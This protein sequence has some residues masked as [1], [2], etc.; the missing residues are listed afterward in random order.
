MVEI[1]LFMCFFLHL[2]IYVHANFKHSIKTLLCDI[3]FYFYQPKL[4]KL[5]FDNISE[6]LNDEPESIAG[7]K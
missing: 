7:R 1:S 6:R 2:K 3:Y 5:F 4:R